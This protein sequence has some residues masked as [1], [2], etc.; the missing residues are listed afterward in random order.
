MHIA[1]KKMP[2][3]WLV[4]TVESIYKSNQT[5][6]TAIDSSSGWGNLMQQHPT[7]HI[8]PP[9]IY[10]V[11]L[12]TTNSFIHPKVKKKDA[13]NFKKKVKRQNTENL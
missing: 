9:N 7:N 11:I 8:V 13:I 1:K 4:R 5:M 6:L 3:S 12:I 10:N 2:S